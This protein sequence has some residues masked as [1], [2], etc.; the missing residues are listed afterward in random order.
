MGL[1]P[2]V[3]NSG[4]DKNRVKDMVAVESILQGKQTFSHLPNAAATAEYQC[5]GY[6]MLVPLDKV[7][8]SLRP[9]F[10]G[11]VTARGVKVLKGI[12][13]LRMLQPLLTQRSVTVRQGD[14]VNECT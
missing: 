6:P 9:P 13:R 11:L 7:S 4:S 14:K 3:S 10:V 12:V 1:K 8:V 2:V 5:F